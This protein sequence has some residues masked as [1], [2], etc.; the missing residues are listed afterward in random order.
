MEKNALRN[1][2]GKEISMIFQDPMTYLNP[3]MNIRRQISEMIESHSKVSKETL[4]KRVI[5]LLTSVNIPSPEKVEEYYPHQLSGGMLQRALIAMALSCNPSLLIA[6]E[7]TTALDVTLQAQIL[8]LLKRLQRELGAS[9]LLIT[10]DLGI[11]ADVCDTLYVMYAGKIV[12]RANVFDI[13][14]N[15]LHPYTQGL[16][17][18]TLSIDEFK[19]D[20]YSIPGTVP[21]LTNPPKGCRFHPRCPEV[22]DIC[23]ESEPVI[24]DQGKQRMTAC[25]LYKK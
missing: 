18:A 16:L 23:R 5:E 24:V 14:E 17:E 10:H 22:M 1:T 20:V 3:V 25:W 15:P 6:D 12:E 8:E 19:K 4:R 2:R 7:P 11:V 21:S 13:Y 9:I